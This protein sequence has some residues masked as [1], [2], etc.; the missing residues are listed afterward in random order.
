MFMIEGLRGP[1]QRGS[2]ALSFEVY[3]LRVEGLAAYGAKCMGEGLWGLGLDCRVSGRF[4]AQ[5]TYK[6]HGVGFVG[7]V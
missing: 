6:A 4:R 1:R 5:G 7:W 2:G 3:R